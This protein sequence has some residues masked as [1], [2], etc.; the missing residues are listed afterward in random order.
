MLQLATFHFKF[1]IIVIYSSKISF[2]KCLI[3]LLQ[4]YCVSNSIKV[5]HPSLYWFY[6]PRISFLFLILYYLHYCA[7]T[8]F[9]DFVNCMIR[10]YQLVPSFTKLNP[11][12]IIT[13]MDVNICIYKLMGKLVNN[14][15][16]K[17]SKFAAG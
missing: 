2:S 6:S 8:Y 11:R 10:G 17:T 15:S 13:F 16:S 7:T 5:T 1:F 4:A 3:S 12:V 14:D 9:Y